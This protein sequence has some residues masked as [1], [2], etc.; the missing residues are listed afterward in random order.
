MIRTSMRFLRTSRTA[1]AILALLGAAGCAGGR[2]NAPVQR[3]QPPV[4]QVAVTFDDLLI[5]ARRYGKSLPA[6]VAVPQEQAGTRHSTRT[7]KRSST[8]V[9]D[10]F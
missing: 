3:A 2:E 4:R 10:L 7:S 1:V 6:L 5:L 9:E 8:V